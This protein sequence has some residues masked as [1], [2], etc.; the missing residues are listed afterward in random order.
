MAQ[1]IV[2]CLE[3]LGNLDNPGIVVANQHV[4]GPGARVSATEKTNAINLEEFKSSLINGLAGA[5]AV[6]HIV[7]DGAL[8][9]PWNRHPLEKHRVSGFDRRVP[10][11]IGAIL[12]ADY[13]RGLICIW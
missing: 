1:H 10:L 3:I 12:V 9:W 4:R 8:V 7:N 6:G 2:T 5:I 13:V 11:C